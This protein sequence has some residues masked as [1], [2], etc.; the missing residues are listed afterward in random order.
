MGWLLASCSKGWRRNCSTSLRR[1]RRIITTIGSSGNCARNQPGS[2]I[3]RSNHDWTGLDHHVT[4]TAPKSALLIHDITKSAGLLCYELCKQQGVT[5]P[6]L[7][8]LVH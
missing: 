3:C 5:S 1:L 6:A 4:E 7:D 8:R 2:P